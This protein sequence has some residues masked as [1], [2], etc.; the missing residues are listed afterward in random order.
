MQNYSFVEVTAENLEQYPQ[1]ICFINAKHPLHHLKLQ[2]LREQFDRGIRI[3]L[4]FLEGE[5]K[6][7]GF[8]EYTPGEECWR[9]IDAAGYMV[10]HCLWTNGK[11]FQHQG[12][13]TAL[14][15]EVE[16]DAR[17]TAGVAL[18]TS[19]KGFMADRS[20]FLK[21]GYSEVESSGKEQLLVKRFEERESPKI[22]EWQSRLAEIEELTIIYSRQCPWVARFI[23]EVQEVLKEYSLKPVIREL[24]TAREAQDA[25]SLYSSFNLIYKGKLLADRYISLT[26]FKNIV[27]KEIL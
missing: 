8:V 26:R 16:Q 1:V 2:W 25:P 7:V 10:I 21:N 5:K 12:L 9:A 22:R 4:L 23:E 20:L 13:G 24:K 3:K 27:K 6:P 15:N 14:L 19:D 11:K 17:G 18:V